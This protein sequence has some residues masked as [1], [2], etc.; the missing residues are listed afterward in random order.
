ARSAA[1]F[2]SF[3][4]PQAFPEGC[5]QHPSYTQAHGGVAGA[6]A[7][8]LKAAFDGA[9][10]WRALG[11]GSLKLASGDGLALE[12][13]SGADAGQITVNGEIEKLASN[14]ALARNFAGVHWRSD[15]EAGIRLGEAM[16]L[17][18]LADQRQ[19]YGEAFSGFTITKF[20]GTT[21]TA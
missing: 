4:L 9:I 1:R 5:P 19:L 12:E 16:A 21:I 20:D 11:D 2:G 3:L 7:T 10:P 15:Y 6:C 8:I 18:V 14:I 17:S 13:Y